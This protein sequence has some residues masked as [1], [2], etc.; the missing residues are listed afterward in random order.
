MAKRVMDTPSCSTAAVLKLAPVH[1]ERRE[2][3]LDL[4]DNALRITAAAQGPLSPPEGSANTSTASYANTVPAAAAVAAFCACLSWSNHG[5]QFAHPRPIPR[6][7]FC[8]ATPCMVPGAWAVTAL[9]PL[10]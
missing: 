6:M 5:S 1:L 10:T 2:S 7:E 9:L 3:G 4:Q 8:C